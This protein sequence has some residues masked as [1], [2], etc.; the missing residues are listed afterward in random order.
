MPLAPG[1]T[2]GTAASRDGRSPVPS[3]KRGADGSKDSER[4]LLDDYT[5]GEELGQGAFGVVYAC[6]RRG[7]KE[8]RRAVKMVDKV[9]TP[10]KEI[11]KEAE[12]LDKVDHVNVIKFHEV[13]Y[14][15]CFV[16][17]VMDRYM[18]GDL[19]A[20]MQHHWENSGRIPC[21]AVKH[22]KRQC[23]VALKV[24]HEKGIVHRDVKGDNY[25][26]DRINILDKDCL[27]VLTDFGTA[28]KCRVDERV[29]GF[30]GTRTYWSPEFYANDY[31]VKV[32][33][34]AFGVIVYGLLEGRFP[35]KDEE[36]VKLRKPKL[37]NDLP[38]DCVDFVRSLLKK[39]DGRRSSSADAVAH[40]WIRED[41]KSPSFVPGQISQDDGRNTPRGAPE[42]WKKD[43]KERLAEARVAPKNRDRRYELV[44]RL[45]KA[46]KA[47]QNEVS[48]QHF[49]NQSW[50]VVM[51]HEQK[52]VKF[53]WWPLAKVT[54]EGVFDPKAGDEI[55]GSIKE[56][57]EANSSSALFD[58]DAIETTLV[59]HSIDISKFGCGEAKKLSEFLAEVKSGASRLMLDA[60]E[61]KKLVRVVDVVLL[62]I[63]Y[64]SASG[65]KRYLIITGEKFDD[66]RTRKD[67]NRLP[68]TKK[69]PAENVKKVTARILKDQLGMADCK[70]LFD[71]KSKEIFEEED[72][73][74]SY[75]GVRT[76]YRKEIVEGQVSTSDA[77]VLKRIGAEGKVHEYSFEDSKHC[78]RYLHWYTESQCAGLTPTVPLRAPKATQTI[79]GLVQAPIGI[80]EEAL[81]KYLTSA[82][83]DVSKF[84]GHEGVKS[85]AEFAGELA[86]SEAALARTKDGKVVR[87]VD[88]VALKLVK[89]DTK[90]VLVQAQETYENGKAKKDV[91]RLPG[92]KKFT[93]ENQFQAAYRILDRFVHIDENNVQLHS[94][95]VRMVVQTQDSPSYPGMS[96]L[97]RKRIITGEVSALPAAPP[98]AP[99]A[100]V[101]E[102]F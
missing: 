10:V 73:S 45:E 84:T 4:Q 74:P 16:C 17:I 60:A 49:L 75:P 91:N 13:Y 14:E 42:E 46:Q 95:V 87:V 101:D 96:T 86:N 65:E 22:I 21:D 3:G 67:L 54:A 82:G 32:D 100:G 52:T 58:K 77:I 15:K 28:T 99:P 97:Y 80:N 20:G 57:E 30:V 6:A 85:L 23:I 59:E 40:L 37:H 92:S 51:R 76:V 70:V 26:L 7:H 38:A 34:W 78:T 83:I 71:F 89:D 48:A 79:S 12:I 94:D 2:K 98:P 31:G 53:E 90:E 55:S 5:L 1:G 33:V 9:E 11:K 18:G 56:E 25:L 66:G 47:G 19:I 50:E 63:S 93:S 35:F 88:V 29:R 72:E 69:E 62:R 102:S 68:G 44:E 64:R 43:A 41:Q 39:E 24:L 8:D 61:Y 81:A 27:V 36:A